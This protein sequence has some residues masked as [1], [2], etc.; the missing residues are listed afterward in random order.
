VLRPKVGRLLP[1]NHSGEDEPRAALEVVAA[2]L[3]EA[4][5]GEE[6]V[7]DLARRR[8]ARWPWRKRLTIALDTQHVRVRAF[9]L[10]ASG[11]GVLVPQRLTVGESVQIRSRDSTIWVPGRIAYVDTEATA[12]GLFRTGVE[13]LST[14]SDGNPRPG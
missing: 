6:P 11:V 7:G 2:W 13:F 12:Q 4:R 9:D 1:G 14:P 5:L 8:N 3:G 10:S